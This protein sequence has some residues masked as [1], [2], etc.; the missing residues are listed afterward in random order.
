MFAIIPD[1]ICH[2]GKSK[3]VLSELAGISRLNKIVK[4]IGEKLTVMGTGW[5]Y[6]AI[7]KFSMI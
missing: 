1:K 2:I 5:E 6:Q 4:E 7:L 3:T